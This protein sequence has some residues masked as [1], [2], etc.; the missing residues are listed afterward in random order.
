MLYLAIDQHRKQL[1]VNMRNENGDILLKRQVSTEWKR[2]REFLGDVRERSQAEGG[3]IAILEICGFNGWLLKLLKEYGCR[4][5]ILVQPEKRAKKKTDRRDANALGEILWV[6]RERFLTGK[7]VQGIRRVHE[8]S[9]LVA[10]NRQITAIRV[11]LGQ[12][13]TRIINKIKH[14]LR[15]HNLEQ[16]CPTKGLQTQA[17]VRWLRNLPLGPI[18]R[19]ELDQLLMQWKLCDEQMEPVEEEIAVRQDRDA[20][21]KLL[22][23]IPGG[24]AYS[25]LALACRMDCIERFPHPGSLPNYWGL[26]PN[27]RNSGDT[28]RLGSIS[29]Q[30]STIARFILGQWIRHLMRK[31]PAMKAWYVRI[32]RRRG[33]QIGRVAVMRRLSAIMEEMVK[34]NQP[35]VIGGLSQATAKPHE[36]QPSPSNPR[37]AIRKTRA[38]LASPRKTRKTQKGVAS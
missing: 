36:P 34:K 9:E 35:Y 15:K 27:C 24:A 12:F 30:G 1:T 26:T 23:T 13:H 25:S 37:P 38:I 31:D 14:L 19:F 3:F 21:A 7:R 18:D 4:E 8:S 11:R 10:E 22:A 6:N 16:E 20:V 28:Q 32:K 29:K 5:V 2:V 17:A 33:A